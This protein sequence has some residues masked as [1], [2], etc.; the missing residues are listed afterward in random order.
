MLLHSRG[1]L[2]Y[3]WVHAQS[4]F[5]GV[6]PSEH[7]YVSHRNFDASRRRHH[8]SLTASQTAKD[9]APLQQSPAFYYYLP[10]SWLFLQCHILIFFF[11]LE[12]HK[13]NLYTKRYT[14]EYILDLFPTEDRV[15][16]PLRFFFLNSSWHFGANNNCWLNHLISQ[17]EAFCSPAFVT[18]FFFFFE[19]LKL[20]TI[21]NGVSLFLSNLFPWEDKNCCI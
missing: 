1:S 4:I 6:F 10:H 17:D 7:Q 12:I 5:P 9:K 14:E 20:P 21:P 2:Q 13:G 16:R 3:I 11:Q 15:T 19:H 18:S 8:D